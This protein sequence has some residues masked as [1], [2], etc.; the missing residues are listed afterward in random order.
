MTIKDHKKR[1]VRG[2]LYSFAGQGG[3]QFLRIALFVLLAR[4]FLEPEDFGI[5]NLALVLIGFSKIIADFGFGKS[6]IQ[7]ENPTE[8]DFSSAFWVNVIIGSILTALI[9]LLA[10]FISE[11][12]KMPELENVLRVL[13]R[14]VCWT[15]LQCCGPFC[16]CE[17]PPGSA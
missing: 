11:Y 6:I 8:N 10:P 5:Y 3:S 15:S 9:F 14:P 1:T 16:V 4:F 17:T 7:I 2:L 13:S 12:Y